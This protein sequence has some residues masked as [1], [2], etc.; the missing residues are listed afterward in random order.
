MA[1]QGAERFDRGGRRAAKG[2]VDSELLA[3]LL[4]DPYLAAPP[5]KS[6]GRER[7]GGAEA[8]ALLAAWESG[9]RPLD[10]LV[11]TLTAFTVESI[12]RACRELL[13]ALPARLVVGGGGAR[14]PTM[15]AGLER[16]LT[17]VCVETFDALGVPADAAEAMAFSLLGRNTLLGLPNHLPQTTGARRAAVLGVIVPGADG[18]TG[19]LRRDGLRA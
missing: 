17:D 12:V 3:R 1:S 13:P 14:N 2:R 4:D 16:A 18:R 8:R 9:G 7:Y 6:T 11:A 15:L 10:D 5:P 19:P